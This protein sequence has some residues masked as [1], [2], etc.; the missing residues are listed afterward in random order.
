MGYEIIQIPASRATYTEG[1]GGHDIGAIVIHYTGA[2]G[3]AR[4]NG[5]YFAGGNRNASAQYFV[6]DVD[7]VQSVADGDTAWAVGNFSMNQRTISIEVCSAGEDFSEAEIER[8]AWLVQKLRKRY[9]VPADNVIRHYDA[10]DLAYKWGVGGSWI[11]PHKS[12]PAPYLDNAKWHAL[13]ERIALG[14]IEEE[15]D[16]MFTDADREILKQL[17]RTDDPTGRGTVLEMYGR[18]CFLGQKADKI[19]DLLE[20]VSA[21]LDD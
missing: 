14:T 13:W 11:D 12:C 3:S 1:R 17:A 16:D 10:V 15:E 4:D 21:K 18:I 9:G 20:E 19:I 8:L 6:D 5:A 7:I 2:E